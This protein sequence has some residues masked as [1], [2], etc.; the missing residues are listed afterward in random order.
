MQ[1]NTSIGL[2]SSQM[3]IW[4]GQKLKEESPLYNMI[5]TFKIDGE[6]NVKIFKEAFKLLIDTHDIFRLKITVNKGIPEQNVYDTVI[7]PL[8]FI[9]YSN[10]TNA[11]DLYS[12]WVK[13]YK[14]RY[15]RNNELLYHAVLFKLTDDKYI[16]YINQHHIITDGW[17][18]KYVYDQ[19]DGLYRKLLA[20][21]YP[22]VEKTNAF[23]TYAKKNPFTNKKETNAFWREK[24]ATIT[25]LP[26]LYGVKA[27]NSSTKA[28]RITFNLGKERTKKLKALALEKELR[29]WTV[30]LALSN[31]FLTVV[32]TLVSKI[33]DINEFSIGLPYHNRLNLE[34]KNI[35]G[36]LMEIFPVNVLIDENEN[37]LSLNEK[38]KNEAFQVIKNSLS[39]KPPVQLLKSF[40]VL[41]NFIPVSFGDFA[42]IATQTEWLLSDHVDPNHPLRIQIQDFNN[43]G[44]Y[45]LLFDLNH[46]VFSKEQM[47]YIQE[48]FIKIIDAF[49]SNKKQPLHDIS[50][51]STPELELLKEWN[52]TTVDFG[53]A[54]MLLSKFCRQAKQTP[55][56]IALVFKEASMTYKELDYKSNQVANYLIQ[57]GI[58]KNDIVAVNV[59]RSLE[60][61]IYIYGIIKA[62]AAYLP[63]DTNTPL[64]RLIYILE[65]AS[66]KILFYNH[67][68]INFGS[69]KNTNCIAVATLT[70]TIELQS[71][72]KPLV[73]T[74]SNDL[75]YVIYTSGSTGE[76]KGVMCHHKGI[77]NRLNWMNNDYPI[78]EED[79]FLQKTPISFDVSLWELFWPLQQGAK[80]VIEN[81]NG[82]KD[83][84]QLIHTINKNEVT[85][86]HFVP[87]MLNIF[88]ETPNVKKC[89][90]LK[91]IF[92]SGEVLSTITVTK[93]HKNLPS[94]EVYNLYGPTEASV[95]VTSWHCAKGIESTIPIGVP[96]ANTQL[97]ILD[98]F[99][100]PV[101]I[102]VIGELHIGGVQVAKGYLNKEELTQKQFIKDVFSKKLEDKMYKTG[103]LA[104]YRND[105]A[106]EYH[107]R[108]DNQVKL[109][110]LRIELDEI[111]N[112]INKNENITQSIV[113]V[114]KED[115]GIEN[116]VAYYTGEETSGKELSE[117]LAIDLPSYMIP[118][119]YM[120]LGEF[121]LSVSGKVDRK[122][123]PKYIINDT[124][125]TES[126]DEPTNEIEEIILTV[127]KEVLEI[128][129]I[130]ININFVQIGGNSLNAMVIT[131][132]LR[133][134]FELDK[135]IITDVFSYATIKTYAKFIEQTLIKLMEE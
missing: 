81:P 42:G 121:P 8:E 34:E 128:E 41:L 108:I 48:H 53:E 15:F 57:Q 97:Y 129:T 72:K 60:M 73:K 116:L 50:L 23:E 54:D 1:P 35:A 132:R 104:R 44:D 70:K 83:P 110:G 92:C 7:N 101:P 74:T 68:K 27:K 93:T 119:L 105:G 64:K 59:E 94:T 126:Y 4:S 25:E 120:H 62:G 98:K 43:Q 77:C 46:N 9:D 58:K 55:K 56:N 75:A 31:I 113:V 89:S 40:N 90:S 67:D 19:L 69:I 76:P 103:D 123:L 29:A 115:N 71:N 49:I 84:N 118:N 33:G 134:A 22:N 102:G 14:K 122:K 2:T 100:N 82:H 127:W 21:D 12:S 47:Q 45:T 106:I 20:L 85:I 95:D 32:A 87:S 66:V 79:I 107:G 88:I 135:L 91:R 3:M 63:V 130:G 24:L 117:I 78:T 10:K 16:F 131:S 38:I 99:L 11:D 28:T 96:V 30:E 133:E 61:M 111:E 52:N 114:Q 112:N 5:L 13:E 80:L 124:A 17:S 18:M 86:G 37:L 6:V 26:S 39:A 36:L 109:R 125:I 51:I 65:N